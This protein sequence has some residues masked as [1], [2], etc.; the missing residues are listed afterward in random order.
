MAEKISEVSDVGDL[1]EGMSLIDN[2]ADD[3]NIG[4]KNIKNVCSLQIV[5][6]T[7]QHV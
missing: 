3:P 6:E 1:L 7:L 5:T 4:G 2:Q